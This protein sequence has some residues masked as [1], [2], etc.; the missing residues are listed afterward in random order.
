[1]RNILLGAILLLAGCASGSGNRGAEAPGSA[2]ATSNEARTAAWFEVHLNHPVL[3]RGFLQRMPKGGDVHSHLGGAVYAESYLAWAA[4]D[5]FCVEEEGDRLRLFECPARAGGRHL[6]RALEDPRIYNQLID[7]MSIRDLAH[8]GRS[9]HDDFFA[10]F[11]EFGLIAKHRSGDMLAEVA[12]RAGSEHTG[13]LELMMTLRGGEALALGGQVG[14]GTDLAGARRRLVEAGLLDIATRARQD[15]DRAEARAS[16]LL[17][18]DSGNPD[19]GCGVEVRYI[20]QVIRTRPPAEVFAQLVHAFELVQA[21]PR[22]V[23]VNLVGPEDDRV[24]RKDYTRHMEMLDFLWSR[25][26]EV[27]VTLH[28]GEL[29]LGMV[30]PK[31]LRF[32]IRQ[33]VEVG[34]ARRIGHG[35]ALAYED[36]FQGLLAR[37][38]E[39]RVA[40][41]VCLTSS[42][43][44]LDVEGEDHP[45]RTYL[46]AEIPLILATDDAGVS[47]IDLSHEFLRAAR[48]YGLGYRSLKAFARNSLD[49]SFLS[50]DSL[51]H[52]RDPHEVVAACADQPPGSPSPSAA[53]AGFLAA[54]ERARQQW[55]LEAE[56]AAFEA[57]FA[58]STGYSSLQRAF[59]AT[60]QP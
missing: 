50:G 8:A 7:Q 23:G 10:T 27:A 3:L 43:V 48:T 44:I 31:D 4:A 45:F 53:C 21:D 5:D 25:A 12:T 15:L 11:R 49:H 13:Y 20:Q 29:T 36:D 26:P 18:C 17:E 46:D 47:R 60:V 51:W 33:A 57:L 32:H 42:D 9:G 56:L 14:L 52:R 1:M 37:M 22:V 6:A 16:T 30:P 39:Q 55:R 35:T 34:H 40:V 54:N 59:G 28:A 24:A 38:R 41:E 58:S 2:L 19:P